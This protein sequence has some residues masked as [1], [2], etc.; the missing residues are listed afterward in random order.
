MGSDQDKRGEIAELLVVMA[1]NFGASL[2]RGLTKAIGEQLMRF[3]IEEVRQGVGKI[4]ATRK[5]KGM[6][7]LAEILDAVAGPQESEDDKV[8]AE[9]ERQWL[10]VLNMPG[11]ASYHRVFLGYDADG[12]PRYAQP[13]AYLDSPAKAAYRALGESKQ[14]WTGVNLD[15]KKKSFLE[16]YRR[17]A[18]DQA[19][20]LPAPKDERVLRLVE[21]IV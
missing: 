1:D 15:F 2:S 8:L 4:M 3:P 21:G 16:A 11:Q 5:F 6:P 7:T 17:F 10:K 13:D 19:K 12:A 14:G 9:G 18:K 20:A